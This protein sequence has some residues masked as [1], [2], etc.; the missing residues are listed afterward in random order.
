MGPPWRRRS[1]RLLER[2]R[3]DFLG[4]SACLNYE[5]INP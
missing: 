2:R 4:T 5:A 3:G 1:V